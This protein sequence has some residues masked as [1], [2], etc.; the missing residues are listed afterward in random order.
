MKQDFFLEEARLGPRSP[1]LVDYDEAP[2][3]GYLRRR[4]REYALVDLA[5]AVM[6]AEEGIVGGERGARLLQGLLEVF[7]LGPE[8]FPWDARPAWTWP[9]ATTSSP[10]TGTRSS[11]RCAS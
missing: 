7:E 6:L 2:K 5:H 8:R 11:A 9:S 10:H 1:V 3:L 4:F